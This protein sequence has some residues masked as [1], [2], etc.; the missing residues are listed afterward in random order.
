MGKGIYRMV[1]MRLLS[2]VFVLSCAIHSSLAG[3]HIDDYLAIILDD[4]WMS[5][6]NVQE[7]ISYERY[8]NR[9]GRLKR[10]RIK[11]FNYKDSIGIT[12]YTGIPYLVKYEYTDS[13]SI[14]S[15]IF[16]DKHKRVIDFTTIYEDERIKR[17]EDHWSQRYYEYNTE[18]QLMK[19]W[20]ENNGSLDYGRDEVTLFEYND[21]GEL[22]LIIELRLKSRDLSDYIKTNKELDV[23]RRFVSKLYYTDDGKL[24]LVECHMAEEESAL[25]KISTFEY[26]Y[27]ESEFPVKVVQ[28]SH[29]NNITYLY[30]VVEYIYK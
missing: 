24:E 28:Y 26:S 20:S 27:D 8:T 21:K 9:R 12:S 7:I 23:R 10:R 11:S 1:I 19:I 3:Q 22:E 18:G 17:T 2:L 13:S 5:G 14:R 29:E 30:R 16:Q 15:Q 25:E 6:N 4:E